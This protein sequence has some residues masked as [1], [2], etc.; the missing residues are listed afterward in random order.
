MLWRCV[1]VY[2]WLKAGIALLVFFLAGSEQAA[3]VIAIVLSLSVIADLL[4]YAAVWQ[5]HLE[6]AAAF[7]NDYERVLREKLESSGFEQLLKG[8]WMEIRVALKSDLGLSK[9][10]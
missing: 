6:L 3:I 10:P 7:G 5:K 4:A 1:V 9:L 8:H 2:G